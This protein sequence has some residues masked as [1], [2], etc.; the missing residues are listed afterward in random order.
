MNVVYYVCVSVYG[1]AALTQSLLVVFGFYVMPEIVLVI[2]ADGDD[3][4]CHHALVAVPVMWI[5]IVAHGHAPVAHVHVHVPVHV[6]LILIYCDF[7]FYF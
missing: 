4:C 5:L 7:Y 6:I 1:S 2:V 3:Y